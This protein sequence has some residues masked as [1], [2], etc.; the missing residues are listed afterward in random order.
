MKRLILIVAALAGL[1]GCNKASAPGPAGA[2][3]GR[4]EIS[5]TSD[6]FV[7]NKAGKLTAGQ[8]VT[9]VVTR[10]VDQTCATDIV[11]KDFG[12]KQPLP[13]NQ[14]VEVH[15]TPDKAGKVHFACAMDMLSGDL[16]VE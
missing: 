16:N 12:I 3:P 9:V 13:L 10:T 2:A 11:L 8:P 1:A 5:V 6:G 7:V 15:F 4:V 14:P